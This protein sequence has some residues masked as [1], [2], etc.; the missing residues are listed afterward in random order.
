MAGP[1]GVEAWELGIERREVAC[2]EENN[3]RFGN[4]GVFVCFFCVKHPV[5][6]TAPTS[7]RFAPVSPINADL[8]LYRRFLKRLQSPI[9][10]THQLNKSTKSP[11][12]KGDPEEPQKKGKPPGRPQKPS[13]SLGLPAGRME[14]EDENLQLQVSENSWA[15]Q[16]AKRQEKMRTATEAVGVGEVLRGQLGD[17]EKQSCHLG[18]RESRSDLRLFCLISVLWLKRWLNLSE[19]NDSKL[20]R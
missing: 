3:R 16:Q 10:P 7:S 5:T 14:E 4:I 20:W 11:S 18:E 13:A 2:C 9:V 12:P 19:A 15:A 6:Q 17:E 1:A 8:R